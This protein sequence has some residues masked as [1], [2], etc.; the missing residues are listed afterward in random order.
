MTPLNQ[1]LLASFYT[2]AGALFL[3][4]PRS[5]Q[6]FVVSRSTNVRA[7]Y[8]GLL[9][10]VSSRRYVWTLRVGGVLSAIAAILL[11][12]SAMHP[13]RSRV[14]IQAPQRYIQVDTIRRI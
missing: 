6:A 13:L 12:E 9:N 7:S 1:I 5:V 4:W 11:V 14:T 10:V 8:A 3:I 2:L